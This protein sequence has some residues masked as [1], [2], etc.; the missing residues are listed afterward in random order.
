MQYAG[1]TFFDLTSNILQ[2]KLLEVEELVGSDAFCTQ[3]QQFP[4][5]APIE[6][7]KLGAFSNVPADRYLSA[8]DDADRDNSAS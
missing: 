4:H 1:K 5:S 3:P 8:D 7:P 2:A 6:H